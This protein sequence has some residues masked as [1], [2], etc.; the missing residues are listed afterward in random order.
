MNKKYYVVYYTWNY[1]A[2]KSGPYGEII[3]EHPLNWAQKE[4]LKIRKIN[5][6]PNMTMTVS[7]W[8]ELGEDYVQ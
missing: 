7:F 5:N 2:G 1:Y 4:I 3:E 8:S 6:S